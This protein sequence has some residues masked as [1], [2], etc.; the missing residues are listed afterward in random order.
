MN[1]FVR[2]EL[3]RELLTRLLKT[4]IS[5][6]FDASK[7]FMISWETSAD[8]VSCCDFVHDKLKANARPEPPAIA[9]LTMLMY[10][11]AG[12]FSAVIKSERIKEFGSEIWLILLQ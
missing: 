3:A 6:F 12:A 1:L 11:V 2:E 8:F 9:I 7:P 4:V 5:C 10:R